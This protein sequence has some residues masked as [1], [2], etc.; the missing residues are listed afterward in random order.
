MKWNDHKKFVVVTLFCKI[1]LPAKLNADVTILGV[2][3][4]K[5]KKGNQHHLESL[6][7]LKELIHTE[8]CFFHISIFFLCALVKW[9]QTFLWLAAVNTRSI[10]LTVDGHRSCMSHTK[11]HQIPVVYLISLLL[12]Q[13]LVLINIIFFVLSFLIL[14]FI[15]SFVY[16]TLHCQ[17]HSHSITSS[18]IVNT[19]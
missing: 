10:W 13:L 7:T 2:H 15:H 6:F 17:N 8:D 9:S 4:K 18:L 11:T 5:Q 16:I 14:A 1:K 3:P 12:I 19:I